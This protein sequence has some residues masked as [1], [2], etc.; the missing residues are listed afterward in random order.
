M[1]LVLVYGQVDAVQIVLT[2]PSYMQRRFQLPVKLV[3]KKK[4][5]ELAST[6]VEARK[7]RKGLWSEK[8]PVAP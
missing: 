5:R 2:G 3:W 8:S 4:D 7:K 1:T 6:E